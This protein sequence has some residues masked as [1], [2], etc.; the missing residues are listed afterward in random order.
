MATRKRTSSTA[1]VDRSDPFS[2][3]CLKEVFRFAPGSTT[4]LIARDSGTVEFKRN[5]QRGDALSGYARSMAAH[6]SAFGGYLV[7]GVPDNPREIV[8]MSNDTFEADDPAEMTGILSRKFSPWIKWDSDVHEVGGGRLGLIHAR[9]SEDKPVIATGDAADIIRD[10]GVSCRCRAR[11]ERIRFPELRK[12]LQ[13]ARS[14]EQQLRLRH[15]KNVARVG[16]RK[17]AVFD[18]EAGLVE[19]RGGTLVM[20]RALLPKLKF[21]REGEFRE[22]SMAPMLGWVGDAEVLAAGTV[23]SGTGDPEAIRGPE[24]MKA[25]LGQERVSSPLEHLKASCCEPSAYQPIHYVLRLASVDA[26]KGAEVVASIETGSPVC[27]QVVERL[28][29]GDDQ[30]ALPPS[31]VASTGA[32]RMRTVLRRLRDGSEIKVDD[33]RNG[34][35]PFAAIRML[36]REYGGWPKVC[37]TLAKLHA[38]GWQSMRSNWRSESRKAVAFVDWRMHESPPS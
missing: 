34:R 37:S 16:V 33:E 14:H 35:W 4:R 9:P 5:F 22:V 12:I 27:Q 24:I 36:P 20:D 30:L 11:S 17:A 38:T 8:G 3:N 2:A 25:F 15:L 26:A 31:T 19:G 23:V 13:E 7:L 10:G 21:M 1:T 18:T 28:R 29:G 32:D 6:A